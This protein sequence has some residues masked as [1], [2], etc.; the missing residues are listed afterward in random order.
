MM[1]NKTCAIFRGYVKITDSEGL[2][3]SGTSKCMAACSFA[4]QFTKIAKFSANR[5]NYTSKKDANLKNLIEDAKCFKFARQSS[6][7]QLVITY[8]E[9][10][11][12]YHSTVTFAFKRKGFPPVSL[13]SKHF[14]FLPEI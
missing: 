7:V 8:I 11:R 4:R 6:R 1:Q 10:E 13:L 5:T 14:E 12:V 2:I 3:I 9:I